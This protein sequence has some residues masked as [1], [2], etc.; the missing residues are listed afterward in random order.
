MNL[1]RVQNFALKII[2]SKDQVL[3]SSNLTTLEERQN[4][5][6]KLNHPLLSK[7]CQVI[8]KIKSQKAEL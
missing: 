4:A 2:F 3:H 8:K 5:Y 1:E 7:K 6:H